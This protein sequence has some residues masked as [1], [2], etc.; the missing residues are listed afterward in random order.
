MF[1]VNIL[2]IIKKN[3]KFFYLFYAITATFLIA[4]FPTIKFA[5]VLSISRDGAILVR[6]LMF[7]V[8]III[9]FAFVFKNISNLKNF[10]SWD[11]FYRSLL[12]F[13]CLAILSSALHVKYMGE[14]YANISLSPFNQDVGFFYRRILEP[15]LAYYLQFKGQILYSIFHFLIT[16]FCIY[17]IILLLENKFLVKLKIWQLVSIMTSGII[18]Q[19]F[20]GPGYPEQIILFLALLSFFIPL[21]IYG[22][23]S[24]LVLMLLTHESAGVFMGFIFAWLYFPKEE[25][26]FYPLLLLAY[27]FFWLANYNF[28]PIALYYGH[29]TLDN[30][31]ALGI[32]LQNIKWAIVAIFFAYKFLWLF[33]LTAIYFSIKNK[34]YKYF[35]QTATMVLV[36]L[37]LVIIPDASRVVGWGNIGVFLAI[38]YSSKYI[39]AR[40]VNLILIINLVLPSVAVG[41]TTN[42]P[43]SFPGLYGIVIDLFKLFVRNYLI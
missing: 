5:H 8:A 22:R 12:V 19:Q 41:T 15:A 21:N 42:G 37:V 25:R 27:G 26:K 38:A 28:N 34:D 4:N 3:I 40:L 43:V 14:V 2:E 17:L 1:K 39:P 35:F 10:M 16:Y 29:L 36:P 7:F 18:I 30:G 6:G 20:H 33:V 31:D 11:I 24:I 9:L 13:G 23:L 32:F